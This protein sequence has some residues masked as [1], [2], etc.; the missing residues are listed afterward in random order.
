MMEKLAWS[1]QKNFVADGIYASHS[2]PLSFARV[3]Y[4]FIFLGRTRIFFFSQF[5]VI[6]CET[7]T[8]NMGEMFTIVHS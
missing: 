2:L 7:I 3:S 4:R 1:F 5:S 6:L 8:M